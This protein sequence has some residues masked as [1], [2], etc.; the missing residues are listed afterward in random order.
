[1]SVLYLLENINEEE[2][3]L[4]KFSSNCFDFQGNSYGP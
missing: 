1:M 2:N 3:I 4:I